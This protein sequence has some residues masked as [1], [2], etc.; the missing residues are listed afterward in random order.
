MEFAAAPIGADRVVRGRHV[1]KA[2]PHPLL[3]RLELAGEEVPAALRTH[4]GVDR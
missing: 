1:T 2:L 3:R 4:D